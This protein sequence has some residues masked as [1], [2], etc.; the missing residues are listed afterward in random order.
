MWNKNLVLR[1]KFGTARERRMKSSI[2]S[3]TPLA[4]RDSTTERCT[5][6]PAKQLLPLRASSAWVGACVARTHNAPQS[7]LYAFYLFFSCQLVFE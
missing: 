4:V 1:T 7:R 3:E 2:S 5:C 6:K